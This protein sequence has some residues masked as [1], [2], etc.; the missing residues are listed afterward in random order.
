MCAVEHELFI[1]KLDT[2]TLSVKL[3]QRHINIKAEQFQNNRRA[4]NKAY[5]NDLTSKSIS[6]LKFNKRWNFKMCI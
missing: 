4:L 6:F 5:Q 2:V 1:P 3:V